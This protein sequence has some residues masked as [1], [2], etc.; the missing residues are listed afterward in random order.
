MPKVI[1]EDSNDDIA[2]NLWRGSRAS[3]AAKAPAL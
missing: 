3:A 2:R 1:A